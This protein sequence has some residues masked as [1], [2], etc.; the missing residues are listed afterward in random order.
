MI[1]ANFPSQLSL[2]IDKISV[3]KNSLID[4]SNE[5][6]GTWRDSPLI[7]SFSKDQ[8]KD[9]NKVDEKIKK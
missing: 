5:D 7:E 8:T 3:K 1:F 6:Q 9:V 4:H 2:S